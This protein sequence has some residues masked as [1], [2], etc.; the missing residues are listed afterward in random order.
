MRCPFLREAQ[1]KFCRASAYRKMIAR[2][3][4]QP[5][6]ERCTS[7]A[8]V[9]CPDAKQHHEEH[10]SLDHCPFLHES[11]VQ[12]CSAASVTRY[13]PYS[14]SVLAQ[15]GT[16]SHKYCELFLALAHP[17]LDTNGLLPGVARPEKK[18]TD[19]TVEGIRIPA[20]LWFS[21]NHMWLDSGT[22]GVLH[23]GIDGFMAKALGEI[24]RLT[25]LTTHG[26]CRPTV[27]VTVRGVDLHVAFPNELFITKANTYLRT[28]PSRLVSD[29]Y[30]PGW[31]F[32][33][34]DTERSSGKRSPL[35]RGLTTGRKAV[36]WIKEEVRR[37]D[38]RAHAFASRPDINGAVMMADGGEFST[39]LM[40]HLN[41]EDILHLCNEFFSPFANWRSTK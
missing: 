30:G 15:C 14:E 10:P 8:Y 22:D 12:Y 24:D 28:N 33:G 25:F 5:E 6:S 37:M 27:V 31:L 4:G 35:Y 21:P 3:P 13:I 9:N 11:L 29:P 40:Q 20:N 41:R 7:R 26:F 36:S 23:L 16:E 1:V 39:G 2:L 18:A 34:T 19:Q 17:A 38:D 32:E